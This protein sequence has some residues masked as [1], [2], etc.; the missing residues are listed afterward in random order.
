ME[1]GFLKNMESP[2]NWIGLE[3]SSIMPLLETTTRTLPLQREIKKALENGSRFKADRY[4]ITESKQ[5]ILT[6][7]ENALRSFER[8][9]QLAERR[10][11]QDQTKLTNI[12]QKL[13]SNDMNNLNLHCVLK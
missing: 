4:S 9:K 6:S 1:K 13:A 8:A 12:N 3:T 11:I 2:V 5:Q 10:R 7:Y